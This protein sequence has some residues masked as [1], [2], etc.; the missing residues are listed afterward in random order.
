MEFKKESTSKPIHPEGILTCPIC[1][2]EFEAN[3]DT[4]YIISGGYTCSWTCFLN[5]VKRREAKK[6]EELKRKEEEKNNKDNEDSGDN[7][8]KNKKK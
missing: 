6:Q 3:G 4:R 2:K 1:N 8:V 5:E 7:K